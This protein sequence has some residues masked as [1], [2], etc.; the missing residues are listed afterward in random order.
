MF[1][2]FHP[3]GAH[4]TFPIERYSTVQ[5]S[6]GTWGPTLPTC[7]H[8]CGEVG[9]LRQAHADDRTPSN[10]LQS[11]ALIDWLRSECQVPVRRHQYYLFI[12]NNERSRLSAKESLQ[13]GDAALMS[14]G[15]LGD[16]LGLVNSISTFH[17]RL[18]AAEHISAMDVSFQ[19]VDAIWRPSF[20]LTH[21]DIKSQ[22]CS[23]TTGPWEDSALP[24]KPSRQLSRP[25][26]SQLQ[27]A[28]AIAALGRSRY[29][30]R[31]LELHCL[32]N[33]SLLDN[34]RRLRLGTRGSSLATLHESRAGHVPD[35]R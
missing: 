19:T 28:P 12:A 13:F 21:R 32:R 11:L 34:Y 17:L 16:L 14:R 26:S 29:V 8:G 23:T 4:P 31:V 7:F 15:F 24:Q 30:F 6:H 33:L 25:N 27:H 9:I 5:Y 35:S 3:T 2:Y 22:N 18:V 20:V 1:C 10:Q